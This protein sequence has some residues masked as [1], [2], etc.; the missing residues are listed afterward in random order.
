MRATFGSGKAGNRGAG[1]R[2]DRRKQPRATIPARVLV[3]GRYLLPDKRECIC[4]V[5]DASPSALALSA[6]ER[7]K[8]GDRVVVYFDNIGRVAGEIV[9]L[10][11]EGFVIHLATRSRAAKALAELVA[12]EHLAAKTASA[13]KVE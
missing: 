10:V 3:R 13:S 6:P 4:T 7:G 8:V 1:Q 12:R 2:S 9:R 11:P 5:L